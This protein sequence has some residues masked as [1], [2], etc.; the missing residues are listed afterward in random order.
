MN[1]INIK[2]LLRKILI[3]EKISEKFIIIHSSLIPLGILSLKNIKTFWT[4]FE[5][6]NNNKYTIIMPSFTFKIGR[7]KKWDY[8]NTKSEMGLLTEYFRKNK[9]YK[10]SIHPFHSICF[11]GPL[12]KLIP[13]HLC[14][15]SFGK[16]SVWEW[17]CNRKDVLNLS[18]GLGLAGGATFV[19]YA[20]EISSVPYREFI[21]LNNSVINRKGKLLSKK[22]T[23]FARKITKEIEGVNDWQSVE[24]DLIKNKILIK[25]KYKNIIYSKMNTYNATDYIYN[26]LQENSCY[27]G[28]MKKIIK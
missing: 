18:I 28:H 8:K 14:S 25:K 10:R 12:E 13:D 9:A 17:L 21:N 16:K 27:L 20:E 4:I 1:L 3:E 19:H 7:K 2:N 23:Y 22:F 15:S 11:N 24:K 5:E 6:I 26:K